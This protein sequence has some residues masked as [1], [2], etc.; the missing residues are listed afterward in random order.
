MEEAQVGEQVGDLLLPEV[1]APGGAVRRQADG[2]QLLLEPLG[3]GAGGEEHARSRP[4]T[5]PRRRRARAPAGR[6]ACAS[7]RRQW[8]PASAVAALSVTSSSNAFRSAGTSAPSRGLEPLELVAE[9]PAEELVHR[10]EHLGPRAMVS[11]QGEHGRRGAP[12]LAEHGDIGMP[13]AVDRLELVADDEEIGVRSLAQEV[14]QLGLQPVR[15]LE[16]VD[17]DRA[18][19]LPLAGA[20]RRIVAEQVPRPELEIL[21]VDRRLRVLG[22]RVRLA[23]RRQ[24][25]LQELAVAGGELLERGGDQH[26]ARLGERGG[27]RPARLHVREGEQALG[28]GRRL[29]QLQ[30]RGGGRLLLIRGAHVVA[31]SRGSLAQRLDPLLQRRARLRLEHELAPGRAKRRVDLHEHLAKPDGAVRRE[32]PPAVGLVGRAEPLERRREGLRLEDERLRLV[33]HAERG[34]DAGG[35]RIGAEQRDGRS[36]GSSRPRRRRA[37]ARGR[38]GPAR[39]ERRGCG[40]AARR[41]PAPCT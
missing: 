2:A 28:K 3:V 20:D 32:E 34:V 36:R 10:R 14:E 18:E 38:R 13:K 30:R 33:Q 37:R 15:V 24:E 7:E 39:G 16:L 41:R 31:Q 27:P 9:L 4:A 6:R 35:Q 22:V 8:T 17:H 23:E 26:V 25:L 40:R 11:R 19:P 29:E 5:P 12:P 1:V 21:E